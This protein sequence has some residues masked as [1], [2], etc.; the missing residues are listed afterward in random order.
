M[1]KV[2]ILIGILDSFRGKHGS[3]KNYKKRLEEYR[4]HEADT[5]IDMGVIYLED[6][7]VP[8]AL[9]RFK[10]AL[11]LYQKLQFT[12]GEAYTQNLIGDTYLTSRDLDRALK[13][14]QESFKLYTSIRSP[15]KNELLEKIRDTE[16]AKKVIEIVDKS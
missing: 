8:E 12:E 1:W 3:L 9:E 5:L 13:H 11:K 7:K 14:Y 2:I 15:L 10:D 16:K 6:E 4:E